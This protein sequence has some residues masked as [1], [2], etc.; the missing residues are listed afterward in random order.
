MLG[1]F[2]V[3]Y[4]TPEW[5]SRYPDRDR[6]RPE[7]KCYLEQLLAVIPEGEGVTAG[8]R[9]RGQRRRHAPV[10]PRGRRVAEVPG[11]R[12]TG[13]GGAEGR[14]GARRAF[15]PGFAEPLHEPL[16]Q[17]IVMNKILAEI[18]DF[19]HSPRSTVTVLYGEEYP[20]ADYGDPGAIRRVDC[21]HLIENGEYVDKVTAPRRGQ[22]GPVPPCGAATPGLAR[23]S[24]RSPRAARLGAGHRGGLELETYEGN[25]GPEGPGV[26]Q[27]GGRLH[28]ALPIGVGVLPVGLHRH[29]RRP[30][31]HQRR[32]PSAGR[33]RRSRPGL[34][35]RQR[36]VRLAGEIRR[37][38]VV[39]G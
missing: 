26:R 6:L 16:P 35:C 23:L 4:T 37:A 31:G 18:D 25:A 14:G 8:L 19:V 33:K 22:A 17:L 36:R 5:D 9:A 3:T 29:R 13:A 39:R 10:V 28:R 27:L 1:A 11:H 34:A 2:L 12:A 20:E 32:S 24:R 30:I 21:N 15:G 38:H 7:T